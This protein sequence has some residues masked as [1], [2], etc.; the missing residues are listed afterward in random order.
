[1]LGGAHDAIL[2]ANESAFDQ[3]SMVYEDKQFAKV[4]KVDNIILPMVQDKSML[5]P[6]INFVI[7]KEFD[8]VEFKIF[9]FSMLPKMI[10]DQ[11]QV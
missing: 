9:I 4:E 7:S 1:M 5:I 2:E 8:I 10:P 3:P 11:K 6:H